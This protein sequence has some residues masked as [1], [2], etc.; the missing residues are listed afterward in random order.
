MTPMSSF[1]SNSL[2]TSAEV[3]HLDKLEAIVQRGLDT[4]LELGNALAE[5]SDASL[6][7]A[8]H[9]TFEAYLRDRW[10]IR[11]SPDHQLP[12]AAGTADP[13]STDL[14]LSAPATEPQERPLTPIRDK[15]PD[16]LTNVW[17]QA[18]HMFGDDD[19]TA[20]EI[21]VTV[22]RREQPEADELLARLGLLLTQS[23]GTIAD[24]AHHLETRAAD[25]DD[26]AREQLRDDVLALHEELATLN[27]LLEPVDWDA[28]H[29]RL[30]TGE[31]PPF[32]DDP[33]DEQDE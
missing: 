25:L 12:Q 32:Q 27:A 1:K 8:T 19:V 20:V 6:Y 30:L 4:D 3:E 28:E 13:P 18:R 17:E 16:S 2:L 5:I 31:I 26:N 21:R 22:H 24:V 14:R 7:R 15:S 33:D 23:T 10:G 9:Q 29:G 11:R